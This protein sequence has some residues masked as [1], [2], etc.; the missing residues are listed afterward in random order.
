MKKLREAFEGQFISRKIDFKKKPRWHLDRVP[1]EPGWYYLET[2]APVSVLRSV[3]NPKE[4]KNYNIPKKI[5]GS[6][7]LAA[8]KLAIKQIKEKPYV[9][10]SGEAN[11]L[12]NRAREHSFGGNGTACL[13]IGKYSVLK[14]YDW[15]FS[16]FTCTSYMADSDGDKCL[17][18]LGEQ[19]WRAHYG[20]PILCSK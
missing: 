11:N 20:W 10:Y 6:S 15:Y 18:N 17:R 14:K 16:Y 12:K 1:S 3:G 13:A 9:V 8:N 5:K 4:K 2:T 7:Y 19:V